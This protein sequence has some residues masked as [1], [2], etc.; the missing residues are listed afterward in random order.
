[1][2]YARLY[3]FGRCYDGVCRDSGQFCWIQNM[4]ITF[5]GMNET[6]NTVSSRLGALHESQSAIHF[7]IRTYIVCVYN[8]IHRSIHFTFTY[9]NITCLFPFFFL[10]AYGFEF[11]IFVC[12]DFFFFSKIKTFLRPFVSPLVIALLAV[13]SA[14]HTY[15][16]VC[17]PSSTEW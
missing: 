16:C 17:A 1:M 7:L 13:R 10:I 8:I 4:L 5:E 12:V 15:A 3:M 14:T 6:A 11:F 2:S 9:W